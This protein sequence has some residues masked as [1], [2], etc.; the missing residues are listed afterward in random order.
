MIL[1]PDSLYFYLRALVLIPQSKILLLLSPA[2]YL[3]TFQ[4]CVVCTSAHFDQQ[5][6]VSTWELP[7][8]HNHQLRVDEYDWML[9]VRE[10]RK[11]KTEY[12]DK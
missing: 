3:L 12:T 1:R 4:G 2:F 5:Q 10:D 11:V 8:V 7:L 9:E 6:V